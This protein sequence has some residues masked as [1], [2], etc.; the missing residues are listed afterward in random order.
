MGY[1]EGV[2]SKG[3]QQIT[4]QTAAQAVAAVNNN[5]GVSN[6]GSISKGWNG[7]QLNSQVTANAQIVA[8]FGQQAATDIG[9]YADNQR[10]KLNLQA[11]NLD[12]TDPEQAASLR[13]EATAW[14]EGGSNRV[15]MHTA[16]GLLGGGIGGA[17]GALTSAEAMTT[18]SDALKGM[19]LPDSVRSGLEQIAATALGAAV[20]GGSGA[21]TALSVDA[22]NRQLDKNEVDKLH[23][24]QEG[25]SPEEQ[26]RLADAACA[27][28]QCADGLS[29]N[30]PAKAAAL[31]SEQ[32]GQG[33]TIE[34]N[35]LASTG[36]FT[37][38]PLDTLGDIGSRAADSASRQ[39]IGR[40]ATLASG[41]RWIW[42]TVSSIS[43]PKF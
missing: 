35:M 13:A 37:H 39:P 32:R 26:Q 17:A 4:R 41:K 43:A 1:S 24:L 18:I 11:E 28:V 27:R 3:Q 23:Q 19:G 12:K 25:K 30:N 38:G 6:A 5:V 21:A 9:K 42:D 15:A 36:L 16:A 33:Y 8:A 14:D 40:L 20:G 31:A 10:D 22:N 2:R 29:D 7:Q 34:Q